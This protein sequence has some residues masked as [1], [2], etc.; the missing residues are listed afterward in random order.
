MV[1]YRR[2]GLG[3][4]QESVKDEDSGSGTD[5]MA[6]Q[7]SERCVL[8]T[9]GILD[10]GSGRDIASGGT[11]GRSQLKIIADNCQDLLQVHI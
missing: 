5:C 2:L 4:V 7:G 11:N 3:G 1:T 10:F 9:R 8:W 6:A